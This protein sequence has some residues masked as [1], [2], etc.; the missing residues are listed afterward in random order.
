M[1]KTDFRLLIP[2]GSVEFLQN[3]YNF[4]KMIQELQVSDTPHLS[5]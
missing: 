5:D 3:V 1:C 4:D 2:I